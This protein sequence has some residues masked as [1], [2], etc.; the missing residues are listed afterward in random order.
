MGAPLRARAARPSSRALRWE[1]TWRS[2]SNS[3]ESAGRLRVRTS[4]S[5]TSSLQSLRAR[6]K[7]GTCSSGAS[8]SAPMNSLGPSVRTGTR[9]PPSSMLTS[10][11]PSSMMR[12]ESPPRVG[13]TIWAPAGRYSGCMCRARR[14]TSEL[15]SGKKSAT[16]SRTASRRF[17]SSK[18]K[19]GRRKRSPRGGA[20]G[21][22]DSTGTG[23]QEEP[24]LSWSVSSSE[25]RGRLNMK[26]WA[27]SQ[28]PA[29]RRSRVSWFSTPSATT[30]S[31]R[32]RP[33]SIVDWTM[34]ASFS[35]R[36]ISRTNERSILISAA[37]SRRT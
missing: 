12:S 13:D 23:V 21:G 33:R 5:S 31:P 27:T 10:Q 9:S 22:A 34:T 3:S 11:N 29:R 8:D 2:T 17:T 14:Q 24:D 35:A 4:R 1:A 30:C 18:E 15:A 16:G 6:T 20:L 36:A 37:C 26:P 25:V 32:L 28:P 7:T 19:A